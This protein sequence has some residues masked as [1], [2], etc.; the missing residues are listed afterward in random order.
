VTK[1]TSELDETRAEMD[2]SNSELYNVKMELENLRDVVEE[3]NQQ[4]GD[5]TTLIDKLETDMK[6]KNICLNE[7]D[8]LCQDL[9]VRVIDS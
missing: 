8:A 6:V 3:Q 9:T 5:K 1:L 4:L 2:K 7:Q